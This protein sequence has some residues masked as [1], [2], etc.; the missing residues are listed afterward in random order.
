VKV[1]VEFWPVTAVVALPIP[2]VL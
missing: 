1:T 2:V